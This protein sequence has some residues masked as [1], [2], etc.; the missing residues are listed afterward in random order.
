MIKNNS[1]RV[2]D[3][4]LR[5]PSQN[6]TK[7]YMK[8]HPKSAAPTAAVNASVLLKKPEAQL[9]LNKH[10]QKAKNKVVSLID[11]ENESIALKASESIIDRVVGKPTQ[12]TTSVNAHFYQHLEDR[13]QNYGF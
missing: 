6:A 2:L 7:A 4:I 9:Y 5:D 8:V 1:K 10:L 12:V 13:K 11:S 3:E